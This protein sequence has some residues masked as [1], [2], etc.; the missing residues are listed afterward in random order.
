MAQ[1]F[2]DPLLSL[3]PWVDDSTSGLVKV[4]YTGEWGGFLAE[5]PLV[6]T[7]D[8]EANKVSLKT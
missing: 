6:I 2:K 3:K 4:F 7:R 8:V 5:D 1:N